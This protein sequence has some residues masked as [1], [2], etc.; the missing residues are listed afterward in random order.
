MPYYLTKEFIKDAK[1]RPPTDPSYDSSTV[2]IPASELKKETRVFQQYWRTKSKNY[3]KV[4]FFRSGRVF[5]CFFNDA[6]L[7]KRLFDC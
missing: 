5:M 6:L 2:F 7:M 4:V 3:D 1:G